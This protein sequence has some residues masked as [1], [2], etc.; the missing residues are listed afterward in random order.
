MLGGV[1]VWEFGDK[2]LGYTAQ[3]RNFVASARLLTAVLGPWLAESNKVR[4]HLIKPDRTPINPKTDTLN[5]KP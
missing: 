4:Y 1:R 3:G 5:P 2:G